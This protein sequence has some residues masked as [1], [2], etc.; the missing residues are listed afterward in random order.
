MVR[1]ES[2]ITTVQFPAGFEI[3][4]LPE[5]WRASGPRSATWAVDGLDESPRLVLTA[6]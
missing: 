6:R 5:G 4:S 1:P 3:D 2:V